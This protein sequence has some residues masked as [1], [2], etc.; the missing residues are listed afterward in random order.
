MSDLAGAAA[1]LQ[2][3]VTPADTADSLGSGDLPVLATPR[4]LAW[5]EAACV[6]AVHPL[7]AEGQTSV[8]TRADLRHEAPSVVGDQVSA[9]AAVLAVDG[10]L[11]RFAVAAHCADRRIASGELTRVVVDAARF[12][13]SAERR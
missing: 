10:R 9:S 11:I 1:D 5:L 4:L 12:L 6:A 8:G 3:P 7:L 13:D 2:R